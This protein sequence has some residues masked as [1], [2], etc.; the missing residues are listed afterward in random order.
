[1]T[2]SGPQERTSIP[3][4]QAETPV[5]SG[6]SPG[7]WAYHPAS[8][9][10]YATLRAGGKLLAIFR[11]PVTVADGRLIAAAPDLLEAAIAADAV[12]KAHNFDPENSPRAELLAAIAKATGQA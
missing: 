2:H 9:K 11:K 12:L 4:E 3:T 8:D 6:H 1:M 10:L 7:K 5:V